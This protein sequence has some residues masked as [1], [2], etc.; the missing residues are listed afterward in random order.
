L[1]RTF[2]LIASS[3]EVAV[4][5]SF[6]SGREKLL[7]LPSFGLDV[8]SSFQSNIREVAPPGLPFHR[9]SFVRPSNIDS[10]IW[11]DPSSPHPVF[12][13]LFLQSANTEFSRCSPLS[14]LYTE[15]LESLHPVSFSLPLISSSS[16][17]FL[18]FGCPEEQRWSAGSRCSFLRRFC[19]PHIE[20]TPPFGRTFSLIDL[21]FQRNWRSLTSWPLPRPL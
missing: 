20:F 15:T 8:S 4:E 2:S 5:F 6:L 10:D 21:I 3:K 9:F 1:S 11:Y 19:P 18:L 12:C 14:S 7:V 16:A 13:L 17:L